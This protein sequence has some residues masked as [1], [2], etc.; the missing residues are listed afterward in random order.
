MSGDRHK[1]AV[2][3]QTPDSLDLPAGTDN[4]IVPVTLPPADPV[5]HLIGE[6]ESPLCAS[7]GAFRQISASEAQS[8]VDRVCQNCRTQHRGAQRTRLCPMCHEAIPANQLP[9]HIQK[10]N[11]DG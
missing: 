4:V 1:Q 9:Q 6:D 8:L 7:E 2:R 3:G 11:R 5:C 10:C